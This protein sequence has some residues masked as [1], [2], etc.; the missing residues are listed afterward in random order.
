MTAA[1]DRTEAARRV[2]A[3]L[4]GANDP[5]R[6]L[7]AAFEAREY[8]ATHPTSPAGPGAEP[9]PAS[10]LLA[11]PGAV[12]LRIRDL[13]PERGCETDWAAPVAEF[14]RLDA[15]LSAGGA[16]PL[17]WSDA[18]RPSRTYD[19]VGDVPPGLAT[20]IYTAWT[21]QD[22]WGGCDQREAVERT[23]DAVVAA[24]RE[25]GRS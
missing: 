4:A 8:V 18:T 23:T 10:T 25:A 2:L 12:L 15:H 22:H 9:V 13:L 7:A 24:F 6:F 20:T 1:E 21:G 17:P 11:H 16:L 14:R 19:P 5:V 3:A